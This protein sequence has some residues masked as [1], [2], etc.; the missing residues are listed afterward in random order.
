MGH[1]EV[2]D[3]RGL[4]GDEREG[5][6][7]I[8]RNYAGWAESPLANKVYDLAQY[9]R[10]LW[11]EMQSDTAASGEITSLMYRYAQGE[12]IRLGCW[13]KSKGENTPCHGDIVKAAIEW[14]AAELRESME[15]AVLIEMPQRRIYV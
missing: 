3:V 1:I 5:I 14:S 4:S 9:R 2:I 8:G 11:R 7:Y 6:D 15:Q 10:W 13:C 12:H